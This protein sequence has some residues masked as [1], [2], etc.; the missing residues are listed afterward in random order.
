MNHSTRWMI[1]AFI[2]L[3]SS[4]IFV[5]YIAMNTDLTIWGRHRTYH[6]LEVLRLRAE[7]DP[8]DPRPIAELIAALQSGSSF[9]RTSAA[10]E[11]WRL[12]PRAASATEALT[13]AL[14]DD[15]YVSAQAAR[16]LGAIGPRA[17]SAVS[18]LIEV[19]R[20]QP[21]TGTGLS[22]AK[23]LGFIADVDDLTV[24]EALK[25]AEKDGEESMHR[26]AK[27]ALRMLEYRKA[28]P[29]T[30]KLPLIFPSESLR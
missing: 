11:L 26:D 15:G 2:L 24:I 14:D 20:S 13:K 12:G 23:S 4:S 8:K 21:R 22:A 9:Q 17:K 29:A 28:N 7:A 25:A 5:W 1:V 30:Q 6:R 18:K 27:F 16:A 10:G 3:G 19:M